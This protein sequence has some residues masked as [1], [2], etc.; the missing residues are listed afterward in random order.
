MRTHFRVVDM[1]VYAA[2]L[3]LLRSVFVFHM[4]TGIWQMNSLCVLL[5]LPFKKE[6]IHIGDVAL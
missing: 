6:G 5:V 4:D 2:L 1:L 3:L